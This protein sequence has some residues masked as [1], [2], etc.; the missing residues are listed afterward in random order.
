M[1]DEKRDLP[2]RV[3]EVLGVAERLVRFLQ[4]V[5]HGEPHDPSLTREVVARLDDM[6]HELKGRLVEATF[7][8]N[9][10]TRRIAG[11]SA[12]R[13]EL[14]RL[15]APFARTSDDVAALPPGA[16]DALR[17]AA[18][19]RSD[20]E[21]WEAGVKEAAEAVRVCRDFEA[22]LQEARADLE[23]SVHALERRRRTAGTML[24]LAR[25]ADGLRVLDSTVRN[26]LTERTEDAVALADTQYETALDQ[27][28]LR[29]R[30]L[31]RLSADATLEEDLRRLR[32]DPP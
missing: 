13:Q 9:R 19:L 12:S 2:A 26:D 20:V 23:R 21:A 15:V 28:E 1:T 27:E 29:I 25:L 11:A 24:A 22:L 10:L 5:N 32:E 6:E 17:R 30:Q 18:R 3:D 31:Y 14:L 4:T 16:V 7:E 8:R